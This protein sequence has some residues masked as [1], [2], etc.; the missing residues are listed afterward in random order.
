MKTPTL[1]CRNL[2]GTKAEALQNDYIRAMELLREATEKFN[3][4]EFNPRD[5]LS[6]QEFSKAADERN[7][8]RNYLLH[9]HDYLE[10][11]AISLNDL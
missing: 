5:Y 11:V 8:C 6:W 1:P 2:H 4:I 9:V 10:A 3:R 7:Q